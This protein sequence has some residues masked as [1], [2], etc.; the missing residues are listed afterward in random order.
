[1][2]TSRI[3]IG[4]ATIAVLDVAATVEAFR[5]G[6]P[7]IGV[8]TL[9][10]ALGAFALAIAARHPSVEL[11]DDLAAWTARTAAATHE[12]ERDL[13]NRAVSRHRTALDGERGRGA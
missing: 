11:R 9:I 8:V 6:H 5:S 12:S 10:A 2:R 7:A 4:A 13:V 1:M 3:W